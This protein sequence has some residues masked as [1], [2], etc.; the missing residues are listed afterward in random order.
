MPFKI[1]GTTFPLVAPSAPALDLTPQVDPF[2]AAMLPFVRDLF[3]ANLSA[4]FAAAS[5]GQHLGG[6]SAAVL[7]TMAA[8][9]EEWFEGVAPKLPFLALYPQ[10]ADEGGQQTFGHAGEVRTYVLDYVL[11]QVNA[12]QLRRGLGPSFLM[13]ARG[14]L[15]AA[16][17]TSAVSAALSAS[18]CTDL[19]IG[20]STIGT[21]SG[22]DMRLPLLRTELRATVQDAD[23]TAGAALDT[24]LAAFDAA[25]EGD[26]SLVTDLVQVRHTP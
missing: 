17:Y 2:V 12:G 3:R 8:D 21:L 6:A 4:A 16:T 19:T 13:A 24:I 5:P 22:R 23:A 15:V 26:G 11:P 7:D 25:A 9:T 10:S 20:R 18:G 14:L 1:A